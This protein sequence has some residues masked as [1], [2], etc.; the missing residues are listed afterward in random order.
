MLGTRE[1]RHRIRTIENVERVVDA[2]QK[3]SAARLSREK[4]RV[5][6]SRPYIEGVER[7]VRNLATTDRPPNPLLRTNPSDNYLLIVVAADKGLCGSYNSNIIHAAEKFAAEH[8]HRRLHLI[9]AG[10]KLRKFLPRTGGQIL[11]ESISI[12]EPPFDEYTDELA[13]IIMSYYLMEQIGHAYVLYTGFRTLGANRPVLKRILPVEPVACPLPMNYFYFYEPSAD[14]VLERLL[15]EYARL[16][17]WLA[18]AE[19]TASEHAARMVMMEQAS[20]NAREMIDDLVL[21]ANKLRQ[22]GIT[23]E[24]L[25]IVGTS[26]ALTGRRQKGVAA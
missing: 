16:A 5:L 13:G 8:R 11:R 10:R 4:A 17:I 7:A 22:T 23:R 9:T 18:F 15:P 2:M 20:V 1:L 25:D 19:A 3:I 6:G 12:P 26:E 24:L 21:E 14:A